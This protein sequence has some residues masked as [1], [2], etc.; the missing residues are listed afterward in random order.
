LTLCGTEALGIIL[1]L[2][3]REINVP[4]YPQKSYCKMVHNVDN[5]VSKYFGLLVILNA[6]Q[7]LQTQYTRSAMP[8]VSTK[9]P[10]VCF[11]V[12]ELQ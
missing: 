10:C 8:L 4:S 11:Q 1:Q 5:Q 9:L 3:Y 6:F 7:R 12:E 2:R